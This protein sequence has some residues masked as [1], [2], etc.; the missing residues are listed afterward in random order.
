MRIRRRVVALVVAATL[1]AVPAQAG[2]VSWA[3]H[4]YFEYQVEGLVDDKLDLVGQQV[5]LA[6]T[7]DTALRRALVE[8]IQ[9]GIVSH[10]EMREKAVLLLAKVKD[11]AS[12]LARGAALHLIARSP[13][14]QQWLLRHHPDQ[15]ALIGLEAM[16][17]VE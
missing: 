12:P 14:L 7:T 13:R 5:L 9:A 3:L 4:R 6:I 11:R 17:D 8:R 1:Y 10:P 2:L 15:A 16:E